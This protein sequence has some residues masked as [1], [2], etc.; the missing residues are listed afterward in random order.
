MKSDAEGLTT[1]KIRYN[2]GN[3]D[4]RHAQVTV[5]DSPIKLAFED[6][7]GNPS[8]STLNVNLKAGSDNTVVFEGINGGWGPDVDQLLVP[9]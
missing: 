3:T 9:V 8:T 2:S 7:G 6:N 5:N 1:V 4:P